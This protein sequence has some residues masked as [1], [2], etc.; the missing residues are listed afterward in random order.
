MEK[1]LKKKKKAGFKFK[2]KSRINTE[3]FPLFLLL[4]RQEKR[5]QQL[6]VTYG[7][8]KADLSA[9][10]LPANFC[11]IFNPFE[12]LLFTPFF[13]DFAGVDLEQIIL[14][15]YSRFYRQMPTLR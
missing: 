13:S 7:L 12:S 5:V 6:G 3:I 4:Q 10:L 1:I 8:E 9:S 15:L 14:V 11:R 2:N